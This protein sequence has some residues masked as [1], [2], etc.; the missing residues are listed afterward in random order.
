MLIDKIL[1]RAMQLWVKSQVSAIDRLNIKIFSK[2]RQIIKGSI[3]KVV[4]EAKNV[5][6]QQ[7]HISKIKIEGTNI[8]V[9]LSQIIKKKPLRLL[10]PIVIKIK[11]FLTEEDLKQSLA[12]PLLSAGLTDIWNRLLSSYEIETNEIHTSYQ[13]NEFSL[14]KSL[15]QF[16]GV[17]LNPENNYEIKNSIKIE[18]DS[19]NS[20]LILPISIITIPEQNFN[21][22]RCVT[23]NLG[24][25][26]SVTDLEITS[27]YLSIEGTITVFP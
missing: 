1:S 26:A 18:I 20:L 7:L 2:D 12:S 24:N 15:I 25:Q 3:P 9:N 21:I 6:Y 11:V 22:D 23:L 8:K 13:W 27:E 10:Q 19:T 17:S 4:I 5:V 16:D 14:S